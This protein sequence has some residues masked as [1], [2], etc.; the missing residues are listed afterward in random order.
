MP[1]RVWTVEGPGKLDADAIERAGGG[2]RRTFHHVGIFGGHGGLQGGAAGSRGR[3]I[4]TGRDAT[5]GTI[6]GRG[7][8][9]GGKSDAGDSHGAREQTGAG[10][11]RGRK[12]RTGCQRYGSK[13][14]RGESVGNFAWLADFSAIDCGE[15]DGLYGCGG[16]Y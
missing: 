16:A 5:D 11:G 8:R 14:E 15:A 2:G 10:I 3:T 9:C 6:C 12:L 13:V 1:W 7:Q 4:S